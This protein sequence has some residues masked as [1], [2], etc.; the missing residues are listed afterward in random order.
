[1]NDAVP[2]EGEPPQVPPT[3][4]L[5][6]A[7]GLTVKVVVRLLLTVWG[8]FGDMV[9]PAPAEGVTV[10]VLSVKVAETVQLLVMALVV[11]VVPTS[12]P[13]QVPPTAAVYPALGV[14]VKVVVALLL[15]VWGVF[16][17]MVPPAPADGVTVHV[18]GP[19]GINLPK[20]R[21]L[22]VGLIE[23]GEFVI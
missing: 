22:P 14:T 23:N 5:Y 12:D 7:S 10:Y 2:L 16:G 21:G 1:M 20:P 13:P 8:V 18:V 6:P 11:Y 17:D 3:E 19:L 15:T 4:A 9:P